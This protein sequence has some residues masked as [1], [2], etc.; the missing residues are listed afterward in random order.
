[1]TGFKLSWKIENEYPPLELMTAEVGTSFTTPGFGQHVD[2]VGF[3]K[4]DHNFNASLVF[5]SDLPEQIG[6]GILVVE[7][8][9]P[10]ATENIGKEEFFFTEPRYVFI[11]N[12]GTWS[13]AEKYC[14]KH[15]GHLASAESLEVNNLVNIVNANNGKMV[16]LGGK[17]EGDI[18]V[19]S[20]GRNMT[21]TEEWWIGCTKV[22]ESKNVMGAD[23]QNRL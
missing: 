10:R 11:E 12:Y 5:P 18:W 19:W 6:N 15:G 17:E 20:D 21:R 23:S 13:M 2:D 4:V 22:H 1:M 8:R 7:M 16:W 9:M 3:Y 14:K